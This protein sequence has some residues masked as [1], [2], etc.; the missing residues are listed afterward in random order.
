[1]MV[2]PKCELP[3]SGVFIFDRSPE[4]QKKKT[5]EGVTNS[6]L[7]MEMQKTTTEE[8]QTLLVTRGA[9]RR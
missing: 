7:C 4:T 2:L 6:P 9:S 1:M 5:E 8:R 3:N